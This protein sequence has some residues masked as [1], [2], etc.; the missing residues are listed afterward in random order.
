M[1]RFILI[2]N[3][4][5]AVGGHHY[6]FARDVL[7]A[8]ASRGMEGVL[9]THRR[10]WRYNDLPSDWLVLPL[11]QHSGYSP[12]AVCLGGGADG[13]VDEHGRP[14][15]LETRASRGWWE[16]WRQGNRER[17]R[18]RYL[19]AYELT[20]AS[21]FR[22]LGIFHDDLI[23]FATASDFDLLGLVRY[24]RSD[25]RTKIAT[26]H[27]QFHFNLLEGR[28]NEHERQADR[29]TTARSQL[30]R[31]RALV[32]QHRLR[33]YCTTES[34]ARQY[35][36]IG[37]EPMQ[38]LPYPSNPRL[39]ARIDHD[40]IPERFQVTCAGGLRREKGKG[41]FQSLIEQLEE[42]PLAERLK[43]FVQSGRR[44]RWS[45]D[46][47]ARLV[48]LIVARHPLNSEQYAKLIRTSDVGLFLYDGRRYAARCS[49]VLVEMLSAGIPVIVP[50]ACWLSDQLAS[51]QTLWMDR[52]A[53]R[54]RD[55]PFQS[56]A[57]AEA[58]WAWPD[59]AAQ[60]L[61][62]IEANEPFPPGVHGE[63]AAKSESAD[64][65]P[66]LSIFRCEQAPVRL[67]VDRPEHAR[68]LSVSL[69]GAFAEPL[70]PLARVRCRFLPSR[71]ERAEPHGVVGLSA[72]D[73]WQIPRLLAEMARHY[74]HYRQSAEAFAEGWRQQH[75]PRRVVDL[76]ATE[77]AQTPPSS[78]RA[79]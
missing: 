60:A 72:A 56:A 15:C 46:R 17:Q 70:P 40:E 69:R 73:P 18:Q 77:A 42:H 25:P 41:C 53:R 65:P 47:T 49:G 30:D 71:G 34:L 74:A 32:P 23:L 20:L 48:E 62:E 19:R 52:L 1:A 3:S 22:R 5:E 43:I 33:Y 29:L 58:R 79:A 67:L 57:H 64:A 10:F 63:F 12:H 36:R 66:A 55:L 50:P 16:R 27:L 11:F 31:A 21:A 24:L 9:V 37:L 8:A 6:Q 45:R 35:R 68:E 4:L 78:V 76:L 14:L 51:A 38:E 75:D 44:L 54:Y 2:D 26:W 61:V 39:A 7:E 59:D 28:E 13:P